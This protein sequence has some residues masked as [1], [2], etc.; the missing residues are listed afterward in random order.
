MFVERVA[1]DLLIGKKAS[2]L[3]RT[4]S[5]FSQFPAK[6]QNTPL[7]FYLGTL[8]NSLHTFCFSPFVR[9]VSSLEVLAGL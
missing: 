2:E 8:E 5:T 7:C 4:P 1:C 9:N 3:L 6:D